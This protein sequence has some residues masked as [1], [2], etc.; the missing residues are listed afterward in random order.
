MQQVQSDSVKNILLT[1]EA[2]L[3]KIQTGMRPIQMR[4]SKEIKQEVVKVL[5]QGISVQKLSQI[6]K[7]SRNSIFHWK[8]DVIEEQNNKK[9][10]APFTV[11]ELFILPEKEKEKENLES[12]KIQFGNKICLEISM[13]ALRVGLLRERMELGCL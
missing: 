13:K 12:A 6:L 3:R 7:I 4:Y 8:K 5:N 10:T 2:K 1:L 9:N 11:R